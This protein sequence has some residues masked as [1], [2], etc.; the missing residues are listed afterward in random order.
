LGDSFSVP[1]L[2]S[3][4]TIDLHAGLGLPPILFRKSALSLKKQ[5]KASF[6]LIV[7]GSRI[8]QNEFNQ[9]ANERM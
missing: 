2:H 6:G 8:G 9:T 1:E 5:M 7:G 4:L 3:P